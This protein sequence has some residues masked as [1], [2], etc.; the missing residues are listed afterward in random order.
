MFVEAQ[1]YPVAS[2]W[3]QWRRVSLAAICH[4]TAAAM[5]AIVVMLAAAV[6]LPDVASRAKRRRTPLFLHP[7]QRHP[8][9]TAPT[10]PPSPHPPPPQ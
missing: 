1:S 8:S 10:M 5:R 2:C 3:W 6:I 9:Q 4:V 7:N